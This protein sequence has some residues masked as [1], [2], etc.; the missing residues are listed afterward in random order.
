MNH[1]PPPELFRGGSLPLDG[2]RLSQNAGVLPSQWIRRLSAGKAIIGRPFD[3]GQIQPASLDLRLGRR[4]FK[5]AASFLPG[6]S[7]VEDRIKEFASYQIDLETPQI[8]SKNG[9]YLIEL[10]ESLKLPDSISAFA[11]PKS[12]TGRLDIFTRVVTDKAEVFDVVPAGYEGKLWLEV[13]PRTFEVKVVRGS[14]LSQLRFHKLNSMHH[15]TSRFRLDDGALR[16]LHRETPLT[17][18][19]PVIR[20]G[21]NLRLNLTPEGKNPVVAYEARNYTGFIDI[22]KIDYYDP[23]E[24]WKPVEVPPRGRMILTPG[25]FYILASKERIHIPKTHAAEMVAVDPVMGEFRVHYAGFF[26]PGFGSQNGGAGSRAVLEVRT[27]DIP[28]YIEDG[29]TIG[30]L[31][32]EEM[33]EEPHQGYGENGQSNYQGQGLKLSKHFKTL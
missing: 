16:R 29:Q 4:A 3:D 27:Y 17:D 22:S 24:F 2:E 13:S 21:L 25:Q 33:N 23:I 7:T 5:L 1:S 10:E 26:D 20:Q 8:L 30:R 19:E 11:N 9:V 28:F 12:S 14:R 6:A 31:D 15:K 32:F 18:S